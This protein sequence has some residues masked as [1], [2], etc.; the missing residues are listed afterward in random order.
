[1]SVSERSIKLLFAGCSRNE[2]TY[3]EWRDR[4]KTSKDF[5]VRQMIIKAR[6]YREMF[7]VFDRDGEGAITAEE[8]GTTISA[9]FGWRPTRYES[10]KLIESVDQ[11]GEGS[12]NLLEFVQMMRASVTLKSA[13]LHN[14]KTCLLET[15][16]IFSMFD[17]DGGDSISVDFVIS[18]EEFGKVITCTG[19]RIKPEVVKEYFS[20]ID[21]DS[22]GEMDFVEFCDFITGSECEVQ[23]IIMERHT[24]LKKMFKLFDEDGGGSLSLEELRGILRRLGRRPSDS[25]FLVALGRSLFTHYSLSIH[26]LFGSARLTIKWILPP[27]SLTSTSSSSLRPEPRPLL[28]EAS[29]RSFRSIVICLCYSMPVVMEL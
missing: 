19:E 29:V 8:L 9:L 20:Q 12:I 5:A 28:N 17:I 1:M 25:E 18:L 2:L 26:S 23:R 6:M 16:S 14:I 7:A 21:N 15:H 24:E 4:V 10:A 3:E 27:S 13:A 11:D 22:S